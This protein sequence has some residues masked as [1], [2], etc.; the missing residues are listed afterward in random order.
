MSSFL[1]LPFK[2]LYKGKV[3]DVYEVDAERLL[4]V[5][6]NRVSAYDRVFAE[7][8]PNKA[9]VL[10]L[11]SGYWFRETNSI[12]SNHLISTRVQECFPNN[13]EFWSEFQGRVALVHRTTPIRFECVVRGHLDG[14]GWKEYQETQSVCGIQLPAG[15]KRYDPLPE[16]IF[17]PAAKNDEGHD[18]NV[19]FEFMANDLGLPLATRLRDASIAIYRFGYKR[20]QKHGLLLLDTKF[21]FGFKGEE[22]L[23]ID[24]A[25]TPDS[26]RYRAGTSGANSNPVALD[27]QYLR[28]A[29]AARGFTG[30]GDTPALD[31]ET[32]SELSSRYQSLFLQITGE[33][34]ETYVYQYG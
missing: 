4:L 17:T 14:S 1:L 24:E 30:E 10:N 31:E 22:L 6:S 16:P 33:H 23:L 29:L 9:Q 28:D 19:S 3:R 20:V 13:P 27:K 32:I 8:V 5:T 2:H 11:L 21:E 12:I 26:S 15:L 34:L 18:E 7:P 25:L